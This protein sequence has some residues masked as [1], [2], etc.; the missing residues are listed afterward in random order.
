M[1]MQFIPTARLPFLARLYPMDTLYAFHHKISIAGFALALA[2]PLILFVSNPYTLRLLN[3]FTAPGRARAGV[4]AVILFVLLVIS[5]V[6]RKEFKIPYPSWRVV[7]DVFA[8]VAAALALYHMF[9]VNHY[10]AHPL[11]RAYWLGIAGRLG[12]GHRL[13]PA[14]PAPATA[15]PALPGGRGAT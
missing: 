15:A 9:L 10:M 1:G 8:V 12:R 3:L 5:S 11:Q 13:H 6:W 14:D 7:H 2:H 4:I